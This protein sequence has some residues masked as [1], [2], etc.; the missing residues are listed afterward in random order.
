MISEGNKTIVINILDSVLGVGRSMKNNERAHFCPF[1]HHHKKKLQINLDNQYYHCWVCDAKGRSIAKLLYRLDV[2]ADKISKVRAIYKDR[3][4]VSVK[5][6]E[7]EREQRLYLPKEFK[8]LYVQPRSVNPVYNQALHYA[9]SRGIN[10]DDIYKY[11]IGYCEDGMYKNRVIIP[12]YNSDGELNYFVARSF[13][14]DE[15]M[16]YRNPPISRNVIG[17]ENQ[18]NWGEEVVLVEGVFDAIAVKRNAIPLLGTDILPK[19]REKLLNGEVKRI[20]IILDQ[21][22]YRKSVKHSHFLIKNGI[23]VRNIVPKE[24]EDPA[25]LKFRQVNKII[26]SAKVSNWKDLIK[27][28]LDNTI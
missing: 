19:L 20:T 15:K 24:D 16:K 4:V 7:E 3:D 21:D 8:P 17:F 22:A 6:D 1:C 11:N 26:K 5:R 14:R 27:T 25:D 2:S 9:K 28:K 23:E 10:L 18:I 12:S 13:I